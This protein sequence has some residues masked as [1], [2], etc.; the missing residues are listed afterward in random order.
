M[1]YGRN[2]GVVLWATAV[3]HED[4]LTKFDFGDGDIWVPG[5]FEIGRNPLRLRIAASD[6]SVARERPEQTTI[7]NVLSA[8]VEEIHVVDQATALV[9]L[10]IG[11]QNVLAQVTR[12]SVKRLELKHGD[13]VFAQV[14]S[15]TVRH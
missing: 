1:L 11:N 3:D 10:G 14:K 5:Q 8:T 6:V 2:S 15:V 7:L 13:H 9:R 4:G 12:R